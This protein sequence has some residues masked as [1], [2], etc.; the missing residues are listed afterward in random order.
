MYGCEN[1]DSAHSIDLTNL[2]K[3]GA[4]A[5]GR[6]SGRIRWTRHGEERGRVCYET[7]IAVKDEPNTAYLRYI[8]TGREGEPREMGYEVALTAIPCGYGGQKWFFRCPNASCSRRCRILYEYGPYFVCRKCT[9]LYYDSQSYAGNRYRL[10]QNFF[11]A[12][13]LRETMK[14]RYYRG[15]PT[16]KY[17]RYLK[18]T[19][20]MDDQQCRKAELAFSGSIGL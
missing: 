16:R 20:G 13:K 17:R 8:A 18:L 2:R 12:D 14:R 11:D 15:V 19:H 6:W 1:L 3:W 5:E 4:L 9:R 7:K 10:M